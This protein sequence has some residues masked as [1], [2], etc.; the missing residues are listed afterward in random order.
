MDKYPLLSKGLAVGIILL[1]V[2]TA[3]IPL[4]GQKIEKV[5]L[6]MSRGNTLYVGGS[7]PGNYSKIQDA[8]D[9]ASSGD[10]IVVFSGF[11]QEHVYINKSLYFQGIDFP[12]V[13]GKKTGWVFRLEYESCTIEG[14]QI[15]N[16]S[17]IYVDSNHNIIKNN[18]FSPFAYSAIFIQGFI[19]VTDLL[20]QNNTI[21]NCSY[22]IYNIRGND[23][24]WVNISYNRF[25]DISYNGIDI[26]Q[27]GH[28]VIFRNS[29]INVGEDG[30]FI[31]AWGGRDNVTGNV[32]SKCHIGLNV[33][34]IDY[35]CNI[36]HNSFE[37]NDLGLFLSFNDRVAD[38][39]QK[40]T[41]KENNFIQNARNSG[42][43]SWYASP[44]VYQ[45]NYWG[46]AMDHPKVIFGRWGYTFLHLRPSFR[47]DWHPA[48]EPYNIPGM[49]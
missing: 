34:A 12:V 42:Y 14:F 13:D 4:S 17:G 32:F 18:R 11:Y 39:F 28:I 36:N 3:I 23:L 15:Q 27:T 31:Y 26:C 41:I 37:N 49:R 35:Y 21:S 22:G 24:S 45:S 5:S 29:F 9:N 10:R 2:G 7:G 20:I 30:L 43:V 8:V 19:M 6:P 16:G 46:Q 44:Y 40:I 33:D 38:N 1:F 47:I 48:Q 25:S